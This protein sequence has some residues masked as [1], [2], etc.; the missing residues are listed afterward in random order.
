MANIF[1]QYRFLDEGHIDSMGLTQF[2]FEIEN[3][4]DFEFSPEESQSDEFRYIGG[5]VG[6][7]S[8]KLNKKYCYKTTLA[9]S[10]RLLKIIFSLIFA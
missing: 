2:I 1:D 3:E 6:L 7:I 5:I 4:Y 9:S 8:N 10:L